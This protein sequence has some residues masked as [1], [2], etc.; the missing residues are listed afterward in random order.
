MKTRNA[1][2]GNAV[3]KLKEM[4]DNLYND[5]SA[6]RNVDEAIGN[7]RA[8]LADKVRAAIEGARVEHTRRQLEHIQ[9]TVREAIR[10][11]TELG[12]YDNPNEVEPAESQA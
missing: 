8:E 7:A 1:S 4:T 9:N 10:L 5:F 2:L 6:L 11:L 3:V 12:A